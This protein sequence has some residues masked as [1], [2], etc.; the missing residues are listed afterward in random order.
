MPSTCQA[1]GHRIVGEPTPSM[2][3]RPLCMGCAERLD[4]ATVAL[5]AL[6]G[7]AGIG[8]TATW[9][10]RMRRASRKSAGA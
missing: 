1:C 7:I 9:L 6:S 8:A 4:A 2:T 10:H 3:G 5:M